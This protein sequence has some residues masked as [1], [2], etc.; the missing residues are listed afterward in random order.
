MEE[1]KEW[2]KRRS[3][4]KGAEGMKKWKEPNSGRKEEVEGA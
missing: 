1:K 4:R 2:K 3:G